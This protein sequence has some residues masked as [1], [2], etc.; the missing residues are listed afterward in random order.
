VDRS[1]RPH[2]RARERVVGVDVADVRLEPL[3]ATAAAGI[4]RRRF[5]AEAAPSRADGDPGLGPGLDA[6]LVASGP[7]AEAYRV[8]LAAV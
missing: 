7:A 3:D 6:G 8:A 5:D 2:R 1:R 4:L